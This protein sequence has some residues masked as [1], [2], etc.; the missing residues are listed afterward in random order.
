MNQPKMARPNKTS[1]PVKRFRT[2]NPD[3]G[4][5]STYKAIVY[6]EGKEQP[7]VYYSN[8]WKNAF[9]TKKDSN[10]GLWKLKNMI[11]NMQ[12]KYQ[13]AH[14]IIAYA[15]GGG[16]FLMRYTKHHPTGISE[17]QYQAITKTPVVPT[18]TKPKPSNYTAWITFHPYFLQQRLNAKLPKTQTFY[19]QDI[20]VFHDGKE[21]V[22][23]SLASLVEQANQIEGIE[24]CWIY[25]RG[26]KTPIGSILNGCLKIDN[27]TIHKQ[28]SEYLIL[29]KT[30]QA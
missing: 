30:K 21:H 29:Q 7:R 23:N 8:C 4:K 6:F 1:K 11:L 12:A 9:V 26:L 5:D 3:N 16:A 25:K 2:G 10:L 19:S 17:E 14:V 22:A 13:V 18:Y 15:E 24:K 28:A 20:G 27:E